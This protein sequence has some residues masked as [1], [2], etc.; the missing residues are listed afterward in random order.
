[1]KI[2]HLKLT[3][4]SNKSLLLFSPDGCNYCLI[5]K[6]LWM[7][8]QQILTGFPELRSLAKNKEI[9]R[10]L[11]E[12]AA[13][14]I[15]GTGGGRKDWDRRFGVSRTPVALRDPIPFTVTHKVLKKA[16]TF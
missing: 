6:T 15:V 4:N 5:V 14:K 13:G 11:G 12:N 9:A 10:R 7:D 1:M 2:T 3:Y 8:S 16:I